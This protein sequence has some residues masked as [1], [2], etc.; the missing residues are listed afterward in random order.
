[1][2]SFV[3]DIRPGMVVRS[4]AGHDKNSSYLVLQTAADRVWL[5]DGSS[6]PVSKLKL[7]NVRH[8]RIVDPDEQTEF[9]EDLQKLGDDGQKNARIRQL[10]SPYNLKHPL[11]PARNEGGT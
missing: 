3:H 7:K 9:L 1:M 2:T 8:V 11:N 10:L 6:R 4:V 5:C